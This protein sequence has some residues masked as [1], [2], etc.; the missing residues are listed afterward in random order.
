MIKI[1]DISVKKQR[2]L[3]PKNSVV[4]TDG[5]YPTR[6][7]H[8]RYCF[9]TAMV[10]RDKKPKIVADHAIKRYQESKNIEKIKGHAVAVS[11][12]KLEGLANI[13]IFEQIDEFSPS[14][15][16]SDGDL[17]VSQQIKNFEWSENQPEIR[18]DLSHKLK[19]L[20][21]A[22]FKRMFMKAKINGSARGIG[23]SNKLY[24]IKH[25]QS[26]FRFFARE[27]KV[28]NRTFQTWKELFGKLLEHLN[29]KTKKCRSDCSLYNCTGVNFFKNVPS[30]NLNIFSKFGQGRI[31]TRKILQNLSEFRF[32]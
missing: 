14:A 31:F 15:I 21:P 4:S 12:N 7:H 9:T 1:K 28:E 3:T 20:K 8:S 26:M 29:G 22:I 10:I 2:G 23:D 32:N 24:I 11:A 5:T 17:K 30:K 19:N 16:V 13:K 18:Y 25:F 27:V 6:G